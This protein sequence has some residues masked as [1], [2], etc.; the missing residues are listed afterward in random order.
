MT[1]KKILVVVCAYNEQD[2]IFNCL[3]SL[4]NSIA[5]YSL[6]N[7]FSVVC[8]DNSSIDK[9]PEIA[10]K[11]AK[12][13][14][15]FHYVKIEHCSLCVSR[16]TYKY[17]DGFDYVAYIDGDG[18]VAEGWAKK[19]VNIIDQN[20]EAKIISGHVFDLESKSHNL[21]W[22]MYFDSELYG[23]DNYLIGANMVFSRN[24]LT[25]VDGFPSFSPFEVMRVVCCLE[26]EI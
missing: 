26:L 12:E 14:K 13:N 16:N 7:N 1:N 10:S 11:F 3:D 2:A 4:K 15:D 22:D 8:V 24:V 5:R 17:F 21:I 25:K 20:P 23:V 19:L 18:Y 6:D 9:T